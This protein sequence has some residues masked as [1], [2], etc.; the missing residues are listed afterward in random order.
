MTYA[1]A[2]ESLALII[3]LRLRGWA[4]D[5]IPATLWAVR[6]FFLCPI[7][8]IDDFHQAMGFKHVKALRQ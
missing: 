2:V 8:E 1:M 4:A 6:T 5:N 7:T 3:L